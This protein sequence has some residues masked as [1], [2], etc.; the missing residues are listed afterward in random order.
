MIEIIG[1]V[2]GI[3]GLFGVVVLDVVSGDLL[4]FQLLGQC[5]V[6]YVMFSVVYVLY[7]GEFGNGVV[8]WLYFLFG[9]GGVFLFY[10]GNL[11]W[12]ELWCKCCQL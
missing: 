11:L 7:F 12:I 1:E 8:V 6:N 2:S 5:D 9:F 4:V 3:F 10:F